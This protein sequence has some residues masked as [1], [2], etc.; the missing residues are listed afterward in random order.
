MWHYRDGRNYSRF[1]RIQSHNS[2]SAVW[3][4]ELDPVLWG[5]KERD[6][7][8]LWVADGKRLQHFP[9]SF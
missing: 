3:V 2:S 5:S 4:D 8:D 1:G 7:D 6:I 9:E